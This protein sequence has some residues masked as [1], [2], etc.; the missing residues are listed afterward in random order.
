MK[1]GLPWSAAKGFDTF[2]PIG[3][4]IPKEKINDSKNVDLWLKV[5]RK[6]DNI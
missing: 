5:F 4:F 3:E 2:T 6:L 1:R